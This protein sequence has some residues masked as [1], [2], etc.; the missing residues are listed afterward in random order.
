MTYANQSERH[1]TMV[2]AMARALAKPVE[3]RER[4]KVPP[5]DKPLSLQESI[6]RQFRADADAAEA[7]D[8]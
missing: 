8:A 5:S 1:L 7:R 6:E 2:D 4:P 3:K